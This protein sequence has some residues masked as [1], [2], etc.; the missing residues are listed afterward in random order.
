M[1]IRAQFQGLELSWSQISPSPGQISEMHTDSLKVLHQPR[2]AA[3]S[4][5][6]FYL[7]T[8]SPATKSL[9]ILTAT[10]VR[11]LHTPVWRVHRFQ[12]GRMCSASL[13]PQSGS[14]N[15]Q[16]AEPHASWGTQWGGLP[17][18][19]PLCLSWPTLPG[20]FAIR[21]LLGAWPRAGGL[22]AGQRSEGLAMTAPSG[23]VSSQG[24]GLDCSLPIY[25]SRTPH[26]RM[27]AAKWPTRQL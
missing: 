22:A 1:S 24:E 12:R 27:H 6:A 15:G 16:G 3:T 25:S 9:P 20:L 26:A 21:A 18:A 10:A 7:S 11:T 17:E 19:S 2:E 8:V 5:P 13:L 23:F 14:E 4:V